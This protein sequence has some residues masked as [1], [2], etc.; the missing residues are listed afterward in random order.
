M[1]APADPVAPM[2]DL[3]LWMLHLARVHESFNTFITA[4][5]PPHAI[6][7]AGAADGKGTGSALTDVLPGYTAGRVRAY[8]GQAVQ[9]VLHLLLLMAITRSDGCHISDPLCRM[10][11]I[12]A[13]VPG[14]SRQPAL[15]AS[16]PAY[17][18]GGYCQRV[19]S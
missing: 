8:R 16:P 4:R 1:L 5:L 10:R 2:A 11:T 17:A 13:C 19:S 15:P 18:C 9:Q 3:P 12:H 6:D 14:R 7:I